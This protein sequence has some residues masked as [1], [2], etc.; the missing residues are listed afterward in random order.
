VSSF[1]SSLAFRNEVD[2]IEGRTVNT[3]D[4]YTL[5]TNFASQVDPDFN[6]M[7]GGEDLYASISSAFK[8]SSQ[9]YRGQRDV[10]EPDYVKVDRDLKTTVVNNPQKYSE[11]RSKYLMFAIS[12]NTERTNDL[13]SDIYDKLP[14]NIKGNIV[15]VKTLHVKNLGFIP[16]AKVKLGGERFEMKRMVVDGVSLFANEE[17]AIRA[18]ESGVAPEL[19]ATGGPVS[20]SDRLKNLKEVSKAE[21]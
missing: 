19:R 6:Q 18:F 8:D 5:Y 1:G 4:G 16:F 2:R 20:I 15:Y 21:E 10:P 17:D 3:T 13:S 7:S 9:A 12:G 14:N 11:L